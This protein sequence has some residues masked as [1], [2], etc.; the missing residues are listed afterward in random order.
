MSVPVVIAIRPEPGLAATLAEARA[1]GLTV[2]GY[3]LFTIEQTAWDCPDAT[4]F[5]GILAGSANAFRLGGPALAQLRALPV[6]VVGAATARAAEAAGFNVATTGEGG[7]QAVLDTL[8]GQRLLRLAGAEHIA[9]VT[10]PGSTIETRVVYAAR[11]LPLPPPL[12]RQLGEGAL[13]LLHSGEAARHFAGL[14]DAARID[15]SHIGL[16]CLAPRIAEVAGKD[17]NFIKIANERTDRAL[18]ALAGQMCEN[19]RIGG[20]G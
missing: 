9:L 7:L 11:A 18:L 2:E 20:M 5:D 3:P 16:A 10:P 13:V 15:R 8:P 1:M 19:A 4:R 14:C 12:A 17:W 6:H